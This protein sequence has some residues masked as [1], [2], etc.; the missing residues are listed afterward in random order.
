MWILVQ[1]IHKVWHWWHYIDIVSWEQ[2]YETKYNHYEN[3]H[4]DFCWNGKDER[5]V[6]RIW[7][8]DSNEYIT[9]CINCIKDFNKR[10]KNT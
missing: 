3:V 2:K 8:W 1:D 4:C 10:L 5:F 7:N 6:K 9:I